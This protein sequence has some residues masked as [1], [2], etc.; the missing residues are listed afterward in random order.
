MSRY[1]LVVVAM[2]LLLVILACGTSAPA[3]AAVEPAAAEPAAAK[4]APAVK[5]AEKSSLETLLSRWES[6]RCPNP[7]LCLHRAPW[8]V[9]AAW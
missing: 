6:Q 2:L 5:P 3:P 9:L 7:P 8:P 1:I 4:Q